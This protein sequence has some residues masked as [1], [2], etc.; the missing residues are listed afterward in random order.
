MSHPVECLFEV[1]ENMIEVLLVL[2]LRLTKY[3]EVEFSITL[4]LNSEYH[5]T[6]LASLYLPQETYRINYII[7]VIYLFIGIFACIE[8]CF[9]HGSFYSYFHIYTNLVTDLYK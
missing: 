2:E 1:N 4:T 7:G 6:G 3:P 9:V 8:L 5:Y